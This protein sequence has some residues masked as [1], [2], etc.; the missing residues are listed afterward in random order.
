MIYRFFVAGTDTGVGKTLISSALLCKA[1]QQGYATFGLKP[2]AAGCIGEPPTNRDALL[3]QRHSSV[4]LDYDWH[5]PVALRAAIAP[6]IAAEQEGCAQSLQL[7]SL[8]ERCEN[9]LT[10]ALETRGEPGVDSWQLVEGAG[11][12]MVP[13]NHQHTLADLALSLGTPVILVVGI[14]LG[15]IN[16]ALLSI[17]AIQSK[18]LKIAGWVAN[19]LSPD[20]EAEK[21]NLEFLT[22]AMQ[23]AR[24]PLLG[25]VPYN[26]DLDI[27]ESNTEHFLPTPADI[28]R[29]AEFLTLPN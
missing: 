29:V 12:W 16:H 23:N 20:M 24:V 7:P 8:T 4:Q 27:E 10:K 28:E 26:P 2:V 5:N 25:R 18:G 14:R 15:C 13:L 22:Q 6:H 17:Q 21:N 1:G 9:S 3:L 11:G 19:S